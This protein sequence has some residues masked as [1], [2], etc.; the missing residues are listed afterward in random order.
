MDRVVGS[1]AGADEKLRIDDPAFAILDIPN[2]KRIHVMNQQSERNLVTW[3][4]QIAAHVAKYDFVSRMM[5]L[6]GRVE[7]LVQP[8]IEP[9]GLLADYALEGQVFVPIFEGFES[10]KLGI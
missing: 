7:L 4:A 2:R 5:P 8:T 6:S 10:S 3:D 1:L 9:K